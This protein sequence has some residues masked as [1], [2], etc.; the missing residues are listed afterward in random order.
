MRGPLTMQR[1]AEVL[2]YADVSSAPDA[3]KVPPS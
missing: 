1:P 2:W 3:G